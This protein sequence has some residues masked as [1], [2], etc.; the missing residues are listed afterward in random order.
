MIR[1]T[2]PLKC[3]HAGLYR[4][5]SGSGILQFSQMIRDPLF[6]TPRLERP[7]RRPIVPTVPMQLPCSLSHTPARRRRVVPAPRI[8]AAAGA[9]L[10]A[11]PSPGYVRGSVGHI[12]RTARAA[13][14]RSVTRRD[15]VVGTRSV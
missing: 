14:S 1:G 8:A 11:D 9:P 3:V 13:I 12:D 10:P 15:G 4:A 5:T 7:G 6:E 2:N